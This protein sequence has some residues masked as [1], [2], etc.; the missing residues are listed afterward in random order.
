MFVSQILTKF[1]KNG[2]SLNKLSIPEA[3]LIAHLKVKEYPLKTLKLQFKGLKCVFQTVNNVLNGLFKSSNQSTNDNQKLSIAKNWFISITY[4]MGQILNGVTLRK[5]RSD[6][7][8]E[9]K[10]LRTEINF[11]RELLMP[12]GKKCLQLVERLDKKWLTSFGKSNSNLKFST[13]YEQ[14]C[15]QYWLLESCSVTTQPLI[16][17]N[18]L[19][20]PGSKNFSQ[21][22][23]NKVDSS[24]FED[25]SKTKTEMLKIWN[26]NQ[27]ILA[28]YIGTARNPLC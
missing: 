18:P 22:S 9:N 3:Y 20:S 8:Q 28:S 11:V 26:L 2:T 14:I 17:L 1:P 4:T 27:T 10:Q 19:Q 21:F 6:L 15:F 24:E 13:R 25:F 5:F 7:H 12:I 16:E 23:L